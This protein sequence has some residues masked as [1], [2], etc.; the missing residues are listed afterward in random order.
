MVA[1]SGKLQ[2]QQ[3]VVAESSSVDFPFFFAIILES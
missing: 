2:K 3:S 1:K